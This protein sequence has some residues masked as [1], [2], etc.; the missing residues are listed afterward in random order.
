MALAI[1]AMEC[2]GPSNEIRHQKTKVMMYVLAIY[3]IAEVI[4]TA[5]HY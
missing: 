4:L 3:I 5:V 1:D 2:C